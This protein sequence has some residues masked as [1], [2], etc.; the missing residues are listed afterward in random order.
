M[1][2]VTAFS[3][4]VRLGQLKEGEY[5]IVSGA[6]G[7]VGQAATQIARAKGARV[8][9]LI[10]DASERQVFKSGEV[11]A[12][13]QS[14]KGDLN[15]V[16]REATNGRGA[17]LAL[18]AVGSSILGTIFEALAIGG[19]Q[20]VFSV[21]GGR[22]FPLDILA[23]YQKQFALFGLNTQPFD[24]TYCAGILNDLAP[25]FESGALKPPI[26]SEQFPLSE[27]TQAF[28]RVASGRGG[29]VAFVMAA[30]Q[31]TSLGAKA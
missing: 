3:A 18:N 11:Q 6:A 12:I 20:V 16:V 22:E 1:T 10:R 5:V 23:F 28:G 8:I 27:V 30:G 2:F 13:A 24:V 4:L 19:R 7:S 31:S 21:A 29:Q 26:I 17:D 14:D 15:P 25:L 9:A